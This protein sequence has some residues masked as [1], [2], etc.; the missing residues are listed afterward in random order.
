VLINPSPLWYPQSI[1][2]LRIITGLLMTYHGWE[3]F[4]R[5]TMESYFGW[6][7]FKAMPAP[8]FMLYMGKGSELVAGLLLTVGLFTRIAC[9]M[10]IGVMSFICFV[11]GGG[12]FWYQDQHPFLFVM[13]GL[14]FFFTGP[15]AWS[16]DQMLFKKKG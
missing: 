4:D 15:M 16:L 3:V 14:V 11:V 9:L 5:P 1:A 13:L 10:I 2:L 7:V 6:D 12:K 8:E